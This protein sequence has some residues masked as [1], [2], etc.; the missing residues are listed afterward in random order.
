VLTKC[1]ALPG[2]VG[3]VVSGSLTPLFGGSVVLQEIIN[4]IIGIK[5]KSFF[6]AF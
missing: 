4:E 6:I 1:P 2:K 3:L 5:T